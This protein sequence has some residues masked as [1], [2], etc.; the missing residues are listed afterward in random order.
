MVAAPVTRITVVPHPAK[1][2]SWSVLHGFGPMRETVDVV[3]GAAPPRNEVDS[4]AERMLT[5][6]FVP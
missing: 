4:Q 6:R 5:S 2:R 3:P 1:R